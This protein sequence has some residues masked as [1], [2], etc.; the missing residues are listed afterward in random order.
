MHN[1]IQD[2]YKI[3]KPIS[4]KEQAAGAKAYMKNQFEYFGI[5]TKTRRDLSNE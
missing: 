1:F 2:L 5:Y 3:Y 4:N